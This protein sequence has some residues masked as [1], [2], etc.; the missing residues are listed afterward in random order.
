VKNACLYTKN[1]QKMTTFWFENIKFGF[2]EKWKNLKNFS[3][4]KT[5]AAGK[6]LF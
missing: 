4:E 6:H 3:K 1:A 5:S 2:F